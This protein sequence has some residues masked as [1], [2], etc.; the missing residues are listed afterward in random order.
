MCE[1]LRVWCYAA[2]RNSGPVEFRA[3]TAGERNS[4]TLR[5]YAAPT[6]GQD[7]ASGMSA[8]PGLEWHAGCNGEG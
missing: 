8:R 5:C 1:T 7:V 4:V 2:G 3:V 6:G